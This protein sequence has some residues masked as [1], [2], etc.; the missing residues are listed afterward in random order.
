MTFVHP[1]L[2]DTL[3]QRHEQNGSAH[4]SGDHLVQSVLSF[5]I[6]YYVTYCIAVSNR[7]ALCIAECLDVMDVMDVILPETISG[8]ACKAL[9][10]SRPGAYRVR[11]VGR[12]S[13]SDVT[14][15]FCHA[16]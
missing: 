12:V 16:S 15:L 9:D 14:I 4:L 11:W 10:K 13:Y 3:P 8:T 1:I 7:I 5:V 6:R 2:F